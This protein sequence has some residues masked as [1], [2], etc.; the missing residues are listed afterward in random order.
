MN[1]KT[2]FFA[3]LNLA[4]MALPMTIAFASTNAQGAT[5]WN[6][7][8]TTFSKANF[9]D[10]TQPAN[11]D[12]ITSK[13]WLTRGSTQGLFNAKTET[14]FT[15]ALS[16][17]D[18]EWATGPLSSYAT[19]SYSDW[20]TWA[21]H[22]PPSTIGLD[23]VVHLI[24]DDIYLSLKLTSWGQGNTGGA[25]SYI[26]T[27]PGSGPPPATAP[28]ITATTIA[29]DGSFRFTFTNAAGNTFTVLG[30]TNIAL[31]IADWNVLGTA[32]EIPAGSGMYQFV[33]AGA[34]TNLNQRHY[35]VRSP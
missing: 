25:V 18:T 27:T 34:G 5:V 32:T 13:V 35:I 1:L 6:G 2:D 11:Q 7:P 20:D 15:H 8:S 19:L 9:A 12:R 14:F 31:P 22:S 30:T 17:E 26:R 4:L 3:F 16:P 10:P 28:T 23:A 24:S 21:A 29:T 33:D